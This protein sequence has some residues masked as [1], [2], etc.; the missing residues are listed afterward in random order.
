MSI[1]GYSDPPQAPLKATRAARGSYSKLICLNCRSRKI[2]CILPTQD[3]SIQPSSSPQPADRACI[4]CQQQGLECII[5]K[6]ILGR[7]SSKRKQTEEQTHAG[8]NNT[9]GC[10][11]TPPSTTYDES[12]VDDVDVVGFV[13]ADVEDE[14]NRVAARLP[15]KDRPED[16]EVYQALIDPY[17]L[18]STV[19][20]RDKKFGAACSSAFIAAET[21]PL[22]LLR[23]PV[24]DSIDER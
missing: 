2:K 9:Y 16:H 22:Q 11:V 24:V 8:R 3:D 15:R 5:D 17:H 23:G 6:T 10:S 4:R 21:D 13:L 7:P 19:I 18:I 12:A 20:K 1:N 14:I